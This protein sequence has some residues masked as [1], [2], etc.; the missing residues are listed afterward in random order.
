MTPFYWFSLGILVAV[1][2]LVLGYSVGWI[3]TEMK[4]RKEVMPQSG[5]Y[6]VKDDNYKQPEATMTT[7]MTTEELDKKLDELEV[8]LT[9]DEMAKA[10]QKV[11][12]TPHP[13]THTC[14]NC[15]H[16]EYFG[17]ECVCHIDRIKEAKDAMRGA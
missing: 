8:K 5:L 12:S 9:L 10:I 14:E 16:D 2:A 6:Q 1:L 13:I 15:K 3:Q 17:C 11:A 4:R 7:S